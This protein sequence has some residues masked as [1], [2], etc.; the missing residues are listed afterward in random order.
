[1]ANW[2]RKSDYLLREIVKFSTYID[3]LTGA[4]AAKAKI[5]AEREAEEAQNAENETNGDS[6][7][8][9]KAQERSST[10]E[11]EAGGGKETAPASASEPKPIA[12]A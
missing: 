4:Q 5:Y 6:A 12:A 8:A 3:S 1:M 2:Q 9:Q 10:P 11:P 7:Q